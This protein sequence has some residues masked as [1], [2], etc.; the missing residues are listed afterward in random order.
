[1]IGLGT[2]ARMAKGAMGIDELSEVLSQAIGGEVEITP[3]QETSSEQLAAKMGTWLPG[4]KSILITGVSRSRERLAAVI[5][6]SPPV[7][8]QSPSRLD[9]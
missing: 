9:S 8:E 1:M 5:V 7:R 2:I 4:S 3:I 6:L